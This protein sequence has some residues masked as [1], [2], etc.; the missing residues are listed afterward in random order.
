MTVK[1]IKPVIMVCVPTLVWSMTLVLPMQ[2]VLLRNIEPIVVAP[3]DYRVMATMNASLL[4]AEL[5]QTVLWIEP[6]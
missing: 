5:V 4:G 6:A 3:Q 2:S 1:I